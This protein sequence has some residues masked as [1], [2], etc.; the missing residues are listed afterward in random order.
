MIDLTVVLLLS[1]IAVSAAVTSTLAGR[2]YRSIR[3][4]IA[5]ENRERIL[6]PSRLLR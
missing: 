5:A 2:R 3:E 1:A 6:D 4:Q